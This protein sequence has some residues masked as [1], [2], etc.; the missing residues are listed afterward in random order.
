MKTL[1]D[2]INREIAR[3][4]EKGEFISSSRYANDLRR[5]MHLAAEEAIKAVMPT[6][7]QLIEEYKENANKFL[8]KEK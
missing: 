1:D 3:R 2:V 4:A 5:V 8:G 6:R 7:E